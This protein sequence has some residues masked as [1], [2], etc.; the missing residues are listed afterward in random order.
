MQNPT[1]EE[2][3][4]VDINDFFLDDKVM[5]LK[6]IVDKKN[7]NFDRY[8][9]G[10]SIFDEAMSGGLKD[11]DLVIISGVSGQGKTSVAQTLTYHLCKNAV[12]C[13][14]FS[15]EVS[16]EALNNKFEDMGISDFYEVYHPKKNTTGEINWLKAK[17]K[18]SWIKYNTKVV[19]IDHIDFLSP[20]NIKTSDNETIAL[21]KIA[22]E[23]KTLAIELDIVI[24]C[25]AHLK[26]LPEGQEPGMQDIG[27]S[28]GVF[29]LADYVFMVWRQNF[30]T[31]GINDPSGDLA[32]NS[33]VIKIVKN[34][35][36]GQLKYVKANYINS[37]FIQQSAY[38]PPPVDGINF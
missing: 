5:P 36:T 21:K 37:K 12:P 29:Q 11:G 17:I 13:L 32:D 2:Q 19:F 25:M 10:F 30:K 23:L 34:R 1:I 6:E 26:K 33:S 3:Y 8:K 24:V 9:T 31:K 16:V 18:E 4:E 15:Y 38:E 20:T 22:T 28:A 27:Y 35:E 7:R 14:W